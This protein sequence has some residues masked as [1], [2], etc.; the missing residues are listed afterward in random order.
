MHR[1]PRLRRSSKPSIIGAA[2]VICDVRRH[3]TFWRPDRTTIHN[4]TKR[5]KIMKPQQLFLLIF[6]S[7]LALS[8]QCATNINLFAGEFAFPE[9]FFGVN[10][11][12]GQTTLI[13]TTTSAF[14]PGLDFSHNGVLYGSSSTLYTVNTANG[15]ATTIGALPDLLVSIAFGPGDSLYGVSNDGE[16]LYEIDPGTGL[17][18]RS[19]PLTGTIHSS[20]TP[21]PGEIN[22]IDFAPDGTLYGIGFGLYR[23]DPHTGIASRITPLGQEVSGDLF[24]DLDFGTDGRLRSASFGLSPDGLSNLYTIDPASGL[25]Q[26]VGSMGVGIAGLASVPEPSTYSLLISGAALVFMVRKWRGRSAAYWVQ[27]SRVKVQG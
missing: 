14:Y 10:P 24:H 27:G 7:T 17:S 5:E 4:T 26:L 20:G 13:G 23:I 18:L 19:V 2:S 11:D 16:T 15:T 12:T 3:N 25:G 8:G 9:R 6:A 22:G 21:F 1:T